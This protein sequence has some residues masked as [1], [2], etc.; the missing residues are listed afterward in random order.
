MMAYLTFS[1]ILKGYVNILNLS[2]TAYNRYPS[3]H[4]CRQITYRTNWFMRNWATAYIFPWSLYWFSYFYN[5]REYILNVGRW[6]SFSKKEEKLPQPY[7]L[8][9]LILHNNSRLDVKIIRPFRNKFVNALQ[10][11]SYP[12]THYLKYLEI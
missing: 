2:A 9:S 10:S 12:K 5:I 6:V 4:L 11:T 3:I 7:H 8:F 1:F